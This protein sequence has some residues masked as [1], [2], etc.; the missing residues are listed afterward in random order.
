M[1]RTALL[2]AF[3]LCAAARA[4]QPSAADEQA[5]LRAATT[6]LNARNGDL[7]GAW[8]ALPSSYRA[9]ASE[10]AAAF[11]RRMD[12]QIW[13]QTQRAAV[14]A[15]ASGT[16]KNRFLY[17]SLVARGYRFPW[18]EETSAGTVAR[19]CAK[20]GA[21]AQAATLERLAS[22]DVGAL[23]ATPPLAMKGVTDRL[24]APAPLPPLAA[25]GRP[26][27][28]VVVSAPG[29]TPQR[30]IRVEGV[31]VPDSVAEAFAN[32]A[33][34]KRDADAF[35]LRKEDRM[36]L[37]FALPLLN[38]AAA[39]AGNAKTQEEFDQIVGGFLSSLDG[40]SSLLLP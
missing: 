22:G 23:L 26:D 10:A 30:M 12:P 19:L 11:A 14:Q 29:I 13:A 8:A 16:K 7:S 9:A 34:W 6:F 17:R 24:P 38:E 2:F 5:A 4:A 40:T 31:W 37:M 39:A 18:P 20:L 1:K 36:K 15:A 3:L 27:G 33:T 32:R 35:R 25:R 28:S 21:V